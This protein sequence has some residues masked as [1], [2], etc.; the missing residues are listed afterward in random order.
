MIIQKW[1][2][3]CIFSIKCDSLSLFRFYFHNFFLWTYFSFNELLETWNFYLVR[4][5][6]FVVVIFVTGKIHQIMKYYLE[7]FPTLFQ[8]FHG[9]MFMQI[10]LQLIFAPLK[11]AKK[12]QIKL[13]ST[14]DVQQNIHSYTHTNFHPYLHTK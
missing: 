1:L 12:N 2:V 11:N 4:L 3:I 14:R 10:T 7:Y 6:G 9:R 5:V 13:N 8:D